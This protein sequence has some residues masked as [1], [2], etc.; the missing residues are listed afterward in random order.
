MVIYAV[1]LLDKYHGQGIGRRLTRSMADWLTSKSMTAMLVWVAAQNPARHF[2]EALGAQRVRT[3]EE[4]IGGATIEEIAYGWTSLD[5]L[6][7]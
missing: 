6:M 7:R 4:T 1:Y 3:K 5:G 2:Y